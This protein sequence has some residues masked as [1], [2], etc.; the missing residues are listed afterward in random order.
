M[1]QAILGIVFKTIIDGLFGWWTNKKNDD[2]QDQNAALQGALNTV[3]ASHEQEAAAQGAANAAA[4]NAPPVTDASGGL[5]FG[6][7]NNRT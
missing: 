3:E 1:W 6:A 5:D 2:L 4:N 7:F